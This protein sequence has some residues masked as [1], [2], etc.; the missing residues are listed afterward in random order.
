LLGINNRKTK[1]KASEYIKK[2]EDFEGFL[3]NEIETI[4]GQLSFKPKELD[5]ALRPKI[6]AL[7]HKAVCLGIWTAACDVESIMGKDGW[8]EA[9]PKWSRKTIE[10]LR[11]AHDA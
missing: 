5:D 8:G 4:S 1:M 2:R 6:E 3:D 11:D 10:T 9:I 7:I